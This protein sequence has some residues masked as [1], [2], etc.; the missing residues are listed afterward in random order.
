[1]AKRKQ[2]VKSAVLRGIAGYKFSDLDVERAVSELPD[3]DRAIIILSMMEYTQVEIASLMKLS[4]WTICSECRRIK[5]NL[6]GKLHG[7]ES[8]QSAL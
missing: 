5:T 4:K 8:Q 6:A 3:R 1:M 7:K 2:K